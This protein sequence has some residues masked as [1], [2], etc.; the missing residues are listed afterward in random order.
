MPTYGRCGFHSIDQH[1]WEIIQ[2]LLNTLQVRSVRCLGL[3][4]IV[5]PRTHISN[6]NLLYIHYTLYMIFGHAQTMSKEVHIKFMS[7]LVLI[8]SRYNVSISY[9]KLMQQSSSSEI[10]QKYDKIDG[11]KGENE[12]CIGWLWR[13]VRI[14]MCWRSPFTRCALKR[15]WRNVQLSLTFLI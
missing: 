1:G 14:T 4:Y 12:Y 15:T 7:E 8:M 13:R 9:I 6:K 2:F 5:M 10:S 3:R 11:Q